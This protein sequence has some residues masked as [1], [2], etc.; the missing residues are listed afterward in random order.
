MGPVPGPHARTDRPPGHRGRRTPAARPGGRATGGGTAPKDTRRPSQRWQATPPGVGPPPPPRHRAPTG[1]TS[2]GNSAGPP[3]PH[4]RTHG[5]AA[6]PNRPPGGRAVRGGGR[7]TSD[8]PHNGERCPP[9]GTPFRHPHSVQR[10]P[11]RAHAMGLML[12]PHARTNRTRDTRA[13]EPRLPAPE[14]GQPGEGR[15]LTPYAPHRAYKPRGPCWAP[16]P[17]TR[18]HSTWTAGPGSPQAEGSRRRE[19]ARPRTPLATG[20]LGTAGGEHLMPTRTPE[21]WPAEP[22]YDLPNPRP[23]APIARTPARGNP[24]PIPCS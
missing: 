21:R 17:H 3:H 16:Y 15:R 7:L 19:S 13:A 20:S 4:N 11:A 23:A 12:G 6:D 10:Q 1:H 18:A 2:Q 22:A 24:H 9:P 5:T 14:D 8:A